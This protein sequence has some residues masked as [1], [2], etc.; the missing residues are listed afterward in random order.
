MVAKVL[1]RFQRRK[2]PWSES[3]S[4]Q[5]G[6]GHIGTFA[7]GSELAR[8][9]KGCNSNHHVSAALLIQKVL[10]VKKITVTK[11]AL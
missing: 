7:R 6:Q 4:E 11:Q 9:R 3:S 2:V 8:E 5:I 10:S 1:R